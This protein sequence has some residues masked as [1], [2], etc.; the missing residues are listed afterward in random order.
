M[1][2][3]EE[4]GEPFNIEVLIEGRPEQFLV[5]PDPKTLKYEIF[6]QHTAVG[7]VWLDTTLQ[8]RAWCGEGLIVRE[9]LVP[10]GE[11]IDDYLTNKPV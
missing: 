7:T 1:S 2:K 10:I 8:G 3:I 4:P 5:V 11:Q 9:L 6:D